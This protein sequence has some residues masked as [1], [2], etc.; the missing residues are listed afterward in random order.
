MSANR[1]RIMPSI[2]F[3][4]PPN[5]RIAQWVLQL[6]NWYV[7]KSKQNPQPPPPMPPANE[8]PGDSAE[9]QQ[10]YQSLSMWFYAT[11]GTAPPQ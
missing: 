8:P 11:Y 10:Y 3:P 1:M 2:P 4:T 5:V 9:D 7:N 6:I